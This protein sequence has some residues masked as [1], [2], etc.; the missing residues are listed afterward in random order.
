M[1]A[2]VWMKSNRVRS[3]AL[4]L[5]CTAETTPVVTVWARPKGFPMAMTVS[6]MRRSSERPGATKG[7]RSFVSTL[8][9]ARSEEGSVPTTRA[10]SSRP[11]RSCTRKRA[12][13]SITWLLVRTYPSGETITPEP[14]E[15]TW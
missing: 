3:P 6:P 15:V 14:S 13:R 4:K 12:P 9:T 10:P 7:M 1:E 5:R 8:R 2:S 11:S